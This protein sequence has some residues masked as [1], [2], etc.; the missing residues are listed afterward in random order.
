QRGHNGGVQGVEGPL[1]LPHG[2]AVIDGQDARIALLGHASVPAAVPE[3]EE[4]V[5]GRRHRRGRPVRRVLAYEHGGEDRDA[6]DAGDEVS[7]EC[8]N[9]HGQRR[10]QGAHARETGGGEDFGSEGDSGQVSGSAHRGPAAVPSASAEVAASLAASAASFA[11]AAASFAS[12]SA[13][14]AG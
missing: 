8:V 6:H 14:L 13:A 2:T 12:A 11:D 3:V 4:V 9:P 5:E 1:V 7:G 10:E